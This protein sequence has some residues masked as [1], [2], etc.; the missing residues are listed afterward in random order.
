M[1]GQKDVGWDMKTSDTSY[2]LG[3]LSSPSLLT[4]FPPLTGRLLSPPTCVPGPPGDSDSHEQE[5]FF[6]M[7]PDPIEWLEESRFLNRL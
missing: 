6:A 3:P 5:L 7:S 2:L 1:A 4:P